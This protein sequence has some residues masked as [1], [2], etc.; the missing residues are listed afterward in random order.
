[1]DFATAVKTCFNKYATFRGRAMRSEYWWFVLFLIV[2]NIVLSVI[3]TTLFGHGAD[4]VQ[5][6][7][8]LFALATILPSLAAGARRLHDTGRTGWWL[9]IALI[10]ILGTLVLIWFLTR[11]SDPGENDYGAAPSDGSGPSGTTIPRVDRQ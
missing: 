10:P 7:S 9:L 4:N 1:M 11:P 2:A 8:G 5:L 3:D 6:L